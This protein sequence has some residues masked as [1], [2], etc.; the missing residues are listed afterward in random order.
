MTITHR[1]L[2]GHPYRI[3]PDQRFPVDPL[4]GEPWEVRVL[5]DRSVTSIV[6]EVRADVTSGSYELERV[7]LEDLYAPGTEAEGHLME[8]SRA[9]P[10]IGDDVVWHAALPPAPSGRITYRFVA[11]VGDSH[12]VVETRWFECS[13]V[14]WSSVGGLLSVVGAGDRLIS[15]LTQWLVGVDGP[16]RARVALRLAPGE[17]VVGFGERFDHIDQRGQCLDSVVFEQYQQQGNRTYLPSPFAIVAGSGNG[18]EGWGFHVRTSR[19]T[20]FDVGASDPD[21]LLIE[22]A[23]QAREPSV[24]LRLYDGSP[25]EVVAAHLGETGQPV[26][27][28]DWVF[29]PWMSANE[30]N[31]QARVELEVGRSLELDVPVGVLVIEAWSDESTFTVFRD[32]QYAE[33]ADGAPLVLADL[34]FPA[35][36][37]WPDPVGMIE[38]LHDVGVRVLL[39][40]IPLLPTDRGSEGQVALDATAMVE[41]GLCVRDGDGEPFH[42]RGWWFHGALLPDWTNPA[43]RTWWLDKRRYLLTEM[44]VDG[45][46]TDGGEHAWGDELQY[47][48]GTTGAVSNNLSALQYANSYHQLL[49]E[50]GTDGVT[51]SRSGFTGAA[52]VPCHW[53]GDESSTWEAF[54][55]SVTAG[56]TA[57]TSG[58]LFWGWDIAGFSGEIPSVELWA[59]A[60]AMAALCPIMQYH[61]EFN[62]GRAP[63]QDRTPWNL[64]ERHDDERALTVYR[65]FAHLRERLQ[66]YLTEQATRCVQRRIPMMRPLYF[67]HPDDAKVWEHRFEYHLGDSLLVAPICEPGCSSTTVYLPAGTWVDVWNEMVHE[68]PLVVERA[69]PL[70]E[71]AAYATGPATDELVGAFR[72]LP[73]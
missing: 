24:E 2:G 40:Q 43:A 53:A 50:T 33:R 72:G 60:S 10:N 54:R 36:G 25:A 35:D 48:D 8:A 61:S 69:V 65:R 42:N 66:P 57:A 21:V 12:D 5:A 11:L 73:S 39:W 16:V 18:A 34:T 59:R 64:A 1:P 67:D 46:K 9:L 26:Q 31:T 71:I 28:P 6:V 49:R 37:A 23:L 70:T 68:G 41:Q 7:G 56:L 29:R 51:F 3:E 19:R 58:V 13:S 17:H 20:W 15:G 30:W 38:W 55:A 62:H 27:P 14:A 44:G 47:F 63:N 45:F 22:V 52:T 4:V 32:A